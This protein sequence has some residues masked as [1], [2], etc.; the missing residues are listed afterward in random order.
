MWLINTTNFE[1]KMF[2]T[3]K[4]IPPYAILSHT[5]GKD[6]DELTFKEMVPG[7]ESSPAAAKEGFEKI[8]M[9]CH[10]ARTEYQ[11]EY[12]WVDTCCIDKSSSAELSE[13]INSMFN[14]YRQARICFVFFADLQ[15]KSQNFK[16]CK[17][18]SRGWTLQELLAPRDIRFF[19][20]VWEYRGNKQTLVSEISTNSGIS[21]EVLTGVKG[22]QEIPIAVR[23][24]WASNRETSREEDAAYCLLGI[25]DVNMPM[26]YGEGEKAFLRLQEEI[27]K[28]SSDMSIFAWMAPADDAPTYT[29]IL[30]RSL[31]DFRRS[32]TAVQGDFG[33]SSV[34]PFSINNCGVNLWTSLHYDPDTGLCIMPVNCS[35]DEVRAPA[36]SDHASDE[37]WHAIC[38]RRVGQYGLVRAFPTRLV[39]G[40]LSNY[41]STIQVAPRISPKQVLAISQQVITIRNPNGF[42]GDD[43]NTDHQLIN[44]AG[45]Y[46]PS[47]NMIYA[48]YAATFLGTLRFLPV[49]ER[50]YD[51]YVF[52]LRFDR[53]RT[54]APWRFVLVTG[55]DWLN[56]L[57][58]R[59][60]YGSN[61]LLFFQPGQETS[62]RLQCK[63]DQSKAKR[64][65][66]TIV[67]PGP[68]DVHA[69]WSQTIE[70]SV[71]DE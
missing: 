61:S 26:I 63:N 18:F 6:N 21:R 42:Q 58:Y 52:I 45:C 15:P 69:P 48:G 46:D 17:W 55:Q 68:D 56:C 9:T 25:F 28:R 38:L 33:N 27:I 22:L 29:G 62:L 65:I 70:L 64:I 53:S 20:A 31:A 23:M 60:V 1:L 8:K 30:A 37:V 40:I 12:A 54:D 2:T 36:P 34:A 7:V 14:W 39:P 19:D 49:W 44:P 4:S 32:G 50:E 10:L 16:S 51:S 5:W 13:A 66:L 43:F 24:C 59:R 47:Q 35:L 11:L 71:V 3:S 41:E 57:N 67:P